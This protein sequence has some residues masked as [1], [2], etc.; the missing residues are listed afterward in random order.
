[1]GRSS[2][3]RGRSGTGRRGPRPVPAVA[4]VPALPPSPA[5]AA[6]PRAWQGFTLAPLPDPGA[7]R[8]LFDFAALPWPERAP[9]LGWAA[10]GPGEPDPV[11]V[12][13]VVAERSG[14]AALLHGPVVVTIP[15]P[16]EA[17]AQLAGAVLDHLVASGVQIVFARPQGLDRVW[18]RF[19]FIPVPEET[20]AGGLSAGA[21]DGLYAWRDGS[22]VW[23]LRELSLA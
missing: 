4:P 2:G 7:A 16:I 6:L 19:G 18:V 5:T 23:S 9:D 12:G 13:A 21:A 22:A 20:L 10:H 15:H 3:G 17:A 14:R 8:A 11:L 1:M